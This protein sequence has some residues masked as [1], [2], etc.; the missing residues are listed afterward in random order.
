M[1][2][3]S[4]DGVIYKIQN[5]EAFVCGLDDP[6]HTHNVMIPGMVQGCPV[7]EIKHRAFWNSNLRTIILPQSIIAI[8]DS[9]FDNCKKLIEIHQ[10]GEHHKR[11]I[12]IG[13]CAFH[14]CVKLRTV[15]FARDMLLVGERHFAGCRNLKM[16]PSI[17]GV[18]SFKKYA[19][20]D[21]VTLEE[22]TFVGPSKM[23]VEDDAFINCPKLKKFIFCCKVIPSQYLLQLLY[24][25]V[26]FVNP[27]AKDMLDLF[28]NGYDVRFIPA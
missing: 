18:S 25:A 26:V 10:L 1:A 9:A 12:T 2:K 6:V 28:F 17:C 24:N 8:D 3:F 11:V 19:F 14:N 23:S 5:N 13:S 21:C 20:L 4:V 22:L 27:E 7:T 15:I 16:L